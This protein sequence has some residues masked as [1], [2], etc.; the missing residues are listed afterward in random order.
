MNDIVFEELKALKQ[1][2]GTRDFVFSVS[3]TGVNIDSIKTGWRNACV[4]AGLMDL[5]FH[6][7]RHT[8]ATPSQWHSR[9]GYSRLTRSHVGAHD[10]CLHSSDAG[11]SVSC[12]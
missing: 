2:A 6:D 8:F 9:M 11:E 12:G 4:A 3:K 10:E 1:D 7:T 5:R